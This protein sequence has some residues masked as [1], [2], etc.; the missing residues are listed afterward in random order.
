MMKK[1]NIYL[2]L[3][4]KNNLIDN[5]FYSKINLIT[6]KDI[7]NIDIKIEKETFKHYK[8]LKN[9]LNKINIKIGIINCYR[10][11]EE[12]NNII[13]DYNK[14]YGKEYTEKYVAPIGHSEHHTGLAVDI[15]IKENGKFISEIG[16]LF[17][18]DEKFKIIHS[19]IYKYGFILRYPKGKENITGYNYEPWHLR[20]VRINTAN[21]IYKN[22]ITLEE[23]L[24]GSGINE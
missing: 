17:L 20:Y 11:F 8:L 4:N 15:S 24:L 14:K 7:E 3:V 6:T 16:E 2:V 5:S 23:F 19:V 22:D 13:K 18:L 12:Q 21:Y 1:N 10:S 9:E